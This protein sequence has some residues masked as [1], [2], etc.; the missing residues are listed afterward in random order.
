[1]RFSLATGT[2]VRL[3]LLLLAALNLSA[4]RPP[5]LR[6]VTRWR[7]NFTV[8]GTT[9][10]KQSDAFNSW[11]Y[12]YSTKTTGTVI[13]TKAGDW[14][15][16]GVLTATS[17]I[18]SKGVW[19]YAGG[20]L[21]ETTEGTFTGS[22]TVGAGPSVLDMNQTAG[23]TLDLEPRAVRLAT[24]TVTKD[25]SGTKETSAVSDHSWTPIW[26]RPIPFPASG[27]TLSGRATSKEVIEPKSFPEL[28][29]EIEYVL[30]YILVPDAA[31]E[32]TL[33]IDDSAAYRNWRPSATPL[34]TPGAP[35][36]MRA[37]LVT[38][39]GA[40]PS[41]RVARFTW[42]L[43]STSREPGIS[44]NYPIES[45]DNRLD[46]ELSG[47]GPASTSS[48]DKQRVEHLTR[49]A[50]TDTIDILPF[51]WGGW[52]E[53]KVTAV[54]TDGRA[55]VGVLKGTSVSAVR[56]PP[57]EPAPLTIPMTRISPPATEPGA[58]A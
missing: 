8:S 44:M 12:S 35:L 43:A 42:E 4:Q 46:L 45:D 9:S 30:D 18:S 32:L 7:L 48:E 17:T 24:Q 52:A 53:L 34:G 23:F 37:T 22:P 3:G 57:S 21:V 25:G 27:T 10:G 1:M 26:A 50:L 54:L 6:N 55:F 16:D 33:D 36:T 49:E 11:E 47:D 19:T 38:R 5:E 13:F 31:E 15:W 40:Q 58:T 29:V 41:A 14:N 2:T 51:D 28:G 20:I 56:I 39:S